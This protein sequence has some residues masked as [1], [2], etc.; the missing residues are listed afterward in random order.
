[1]DSMP[2][3]HEKDTA[4]STAGSRE[5][6]EVRLAESLALRSTRRTFLRWALERA[7]VLG[8]SAALVQT[9]FAD[10][11]AA[12]HT[13]CQQQVAPSCSCCGP[14]GGC[15]AN[16]KN[17]NWGTGKCGTLPNCW[18]EGNFLCCDCC[19]HN[20]CTNFNNCPPHNCRT[21]TMCGGGGTWNRCVCVSTC[22]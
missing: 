3:A 15:H 13:A 8:A 21:C 1:M 10:Y 19:C 7:F 9:V 11:A 20:P 17:R 12:N 14:A 16:C 6:L 5:S 2:V 22:C 4:R 18:I